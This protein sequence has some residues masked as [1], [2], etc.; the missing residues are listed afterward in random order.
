MVRIHF[1]PFRIDR[2]LYEEKKFHDK[3]PFKEMYLFV[4][5]TST[6]KKCHA[7]NYFTSILWGCF[8]W[9]V[10]VCNF[11]GL[12]RFLLFYDFSVLLEKS[13][14]LFYSFL[15]CFPIERLLLEKSWS[16]ELSKGKHPS[17]HGNWLA[18]FRY[19]CKMNS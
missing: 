18:P 7:W 15:Q 19:I 9:D 6:W 12:L 16:K 4:Q 13:E 5:C 17:N 8:N 11:R 3:I 1:T 2:F 10:Y 14:L